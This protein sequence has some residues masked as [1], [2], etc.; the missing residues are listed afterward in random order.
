MDQKNQLSAQQSALSGAVV[1]WEDPNGDELRI[2][3]HDREAYESQGYVVTEFRGVFTAVKFSPWPDGTVE[4]QPKTTMRSRWA[5]AGKHTNAGYDG[6]FKLYVWVGGKR[7]NFLDA[8]KLFPNNEHHY[9]AQ[10][11]KK[12]AIERI[13]AI[14]GNRKGATLEKD[15]GGW[16]LLPVA[17]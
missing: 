6:Y 10:Y 2:E 7:R 5:R 3:P 17:S 15:K 11:E 8:W 13:V 14:I 1:Q 4:C 16:R 9:A 12:D